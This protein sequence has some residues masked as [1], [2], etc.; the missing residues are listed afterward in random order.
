MLKK[1]RILQRDG[2]PDP[3]FAAV[4]DAAYV[5]TKEGVV[6]RDPIIYPSQEFVD[7]LTTSDRKVETQIG[8]LI[9][10]EIE[11]K[12]RKKRPRDEDGQAR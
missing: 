6:L 5:K 7:E 3:R 2:S 10:E 4:L 8:R 12:H 9:L 11:E 1:S